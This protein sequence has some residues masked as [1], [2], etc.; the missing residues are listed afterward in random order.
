M[1]LI[2]LSSLK[3]GDQ[4]SSPLRMQDG[5]IILPAQ[6]VITQAH[7]NRLGNYKIQSVYIEDDIY[8]DVVI[9]PALKD[10]TKALLLSTLSNLYKSAQKGKAF[11][12]TSAKKAV[13]CV[14]DDVTGV[15]REPISL[16]NMFSVDDPRHLHGVNVATIT[17]AIAISHGYM[18]EVVEDYIM[19]A[20]LHDIMLEYMDQDNT[21][22]HAK[23]AS[24]YLKASRGVRARVY[25]AIA[26]HHEHYDGKGKPGGY[27][28]D[29][30]NEGARIIS[31]ADTFD[32]LVFGYNCEALESHKA[33]EYLNMLSGKQL[34]P[35]L[36]R[37]F[38]SNIAIYPTGSTVVLSNGLRAIVT[39]QNEQMP[40]RPKVRLCMPRR[41][42]CIELNLLTNRTVFIEKLEL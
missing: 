24:E 9:T 11:D 35:D 4:I 13:S 15:I 2:S 28:Q 29:G 14:A 31:I 6:A 16:F 17:A 25:M 19:G 5:R 12:E 1:R 22:E 42:D 32:N 37:Y 10:E 20:L 30:I 40:T 18:R 41:E 33:V 27:S 21:Y 26:M 38:N 8:D 3:L 39:K 34:D 7:L 36:L 23:K